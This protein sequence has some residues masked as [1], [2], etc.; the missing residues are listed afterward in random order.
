[1]IVQATASP[2]FV[3]VV[4]A[5]ATV[6]SGVPVVSIILLTVIGSVALANLV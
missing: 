5:K 3:T 4:L 6:K 2:V 1:M